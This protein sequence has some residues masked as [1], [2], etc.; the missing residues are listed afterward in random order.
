MSPPCASL[1]RRVRRRGA[2]RAGLQGCQQSLDVPALFRHRFDTFSTHTSS[3]ATG[4][5]RITFALATSLSLAFTPS[6]AQD[7]ATGGGEV[8][9]LDV[10]VTERMSLGQLD[11]CE[12][13][14]LLAYEDYIYRNGLI[15]FLRGSIAFA[16]FV[17]SP[18]AAPA[19][20]ILKQRERIK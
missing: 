4:M 13:T 5:N 11:S 14:Y 20:A 15:T 3:E 7:R 9:L 6:A 17:S 2:V 1:C 10:V 16:A 8:L 19:K 12:I 18:D